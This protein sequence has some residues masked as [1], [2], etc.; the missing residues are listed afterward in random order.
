MFR[1]GGESGRGVRA[2]GTQWAGLWLV[3]G[4]LSFGIVL[5][6]SAQAADSAYDRL[7]SVAPE[8][9]A[10]GISA[11]DALTGSR[12]SLGDVDLGGGAALQG[13]RLT[14]TGS[15]VHISAGVR[16]RCPTG[17]SMDGRL[18]GYLAYTATN[19]WSV[20]GALEAGSGGCGLAPKLALQEG[21]GVRLVLRSDRGTL[22]MEVGGTVDV[23]TG[24][25][26]T[27]SR[28]AVAVRLA[29]G[30]GGFR[31]SVAGSAPGAS[32][33]GTVAGDGTFA[34]AFNVDL[35][36]AGTKV[37][38]DGY[39]RRTA[40][41]GAVDSR[42]HARVAGDVQLVPGAR[43]R[44]AS[45]DWDGGALSVS[46]MLRLDCQEGSLDLGVAGAFSTAH[47]F[48]LQ[49]GARGSACTLGNRMVV[50]DGQIV[51]GTIRYGDGR[52]GIDL[53]VGG[54]SADL[55]TLRLG[56]TDFLGVRL[57]DVGVWLSNTCD[58]CA[59]DRLRVAIVA[60]PLLRLDSATLLDVF[61]LGLTLDVSFDLGWPGLLPT[62][63]AVALRNV[64]ANGGDTQWSLLLET[65]VRRWLQSAFFQGVAAAGDIREVCARTEC[66]DTVGSAPVGAGVSAV[67]G[68]TRFLAFSVRLASGRPV[69]KM[70]LNR[71]VPVGVDLQRRRCVARQC[72][73]RLV[74]YRLVRPSARGARVV[75]LAPRLSPGRYRIVARIGAGGAGARAVR[76]LV[77]K[78]S[79]R[80]TR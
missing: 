39:V 34:I 26:P 74:R 27:Q 52:V 7:A 18:S 30:G 46:G 17:G 28:F 42:L 31:A 6:Q 23:V 4:L 62:R 35:D 43:L 12:V 24:L 48:S 72:T 70:R 1:S 33:S 36:L 44:S 3:L 71:R 66:P 9:G 51:Q 21:A 47:R 10:E 37:A 73:W 14:F 61:D 69:V 53:R 2:L 15:R 19:T 5:P 41:G 55:G 80:S 79:P 75:R 57:V 29:A 63:I 65:H 54:L 76:T 68:R 78:R 58:G 11:T 50:L 13:V 16:L 49:V 77:V 67:K 25:V 22:A 59:A 38:A 40:V 8:R 56:R 20:E 45:V 64:T 32:F 60:R